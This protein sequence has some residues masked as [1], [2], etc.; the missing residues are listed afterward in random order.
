M[1]KIAL[2]MFLIFFGIKGFSQLE[3]VKPIEEILVGQSNKDPFGVCPPT[4][5]LSY[6]KDDDS[7]VDTLYHI[8]FKDQQYNSG[9]CHDWFDN[10]FFTGNSKI[11]NDLYLELKGDFDLEKD[12]TDMFNLNNKLNKV[13][14]AVQTTKIMFTRVIFIQVS[15][16]TKSNCYFY[17]TKKELDKLFNKNQD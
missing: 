1:K 10:L 17:L 3:K 13:K 14:F 15:T 4:V 16:K 9:D 5:T 6:I 7:S 2:F 11:L 8:H 12:K